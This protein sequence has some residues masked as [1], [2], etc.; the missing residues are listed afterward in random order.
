WPRARR[1]G[2][3][4][5]PPDATAAPAAAASSARKERARA[6][7]WTSRR[8]RD[9][10]KSLSRSGGGQGAAQ[11]PA[12]DPLGQQFLQTR[13]RLARGSAIRFASETG[14][15]TAGR[16]CLKPDPAVKGPSMLNSPIQRSG[17]LAVLAVPGAVAQP[18]KERPNVRPC[19]PR[20]K[21]KTAV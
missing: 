14:P 15:A 17:V 9:E 12:R 20:H 21:V 7:R 4:P 16:P 19:V 10:C 13:V 3:R 2:R 8:G 11:V 1:R 18:A 6:T 5:R